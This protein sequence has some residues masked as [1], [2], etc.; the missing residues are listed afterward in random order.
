MFTVPPTQNSTSTYDPLAVQF[1]TQGQ[2]GYM[3]QAQYL[4]P[5]QYGA[6]RSMPGMQNSMSMTQQAPSLWQTYLQANRGNIMG[7]TGNYWV[8][9]YNPMQSQVDMQVMAQRRLSDAQHS[10]AAGFGGVV[11]QSALP[12]IG[13]ALGGPIGFMAGAGLSMVMPNMGDMMASRRRNARM[14]QNISV[15]SV[16]SGPDMATTTGRGFTL[17]ASGRLE[18]DIRSA[19]VDDMVFNQ[20]DYTSFL[21]KGVSSG[22]MD[23]SQTAKQYGDVVKKLRSNVKLLAEVLD[24]KDVSAIFKDMQRMQTMGA[25]IT[26]MQSIGLKEST[27]ARIAGL[28]H[29]EMVNTYGQQGAMQAMQ[30]GLTPYQGALSSMGNAALI[31]MAQRSGL[32]NP[33]ELARL[34]GVQGLTQNFNDGAGKS[35]TWVQE[36]ILPGLT[37]DGKFDPDKADAFMK[38]GVSLNQAMQNSAEQRRDLDR[39]RRIRINRGD[40][41]DAL[42]EHL[43]GNL[44]ALTTKVAKLFGEEITRGVGTPETKLIQGLTAMGFDPDAARAKAK[45]EFNED[46]KAK[47]AEQEAIEKNRQNEAALRQQESTSS[48]FKTNQ[49]KLNRFLHGLRDDIFGDWAADAER[50]ADREEAR[51]AGIYRTDDRGLGDTRLLTGDRRP[52]VT[53][54]DIGELLWYPEDNKYNVKQRAAFAR[55]GADVELA[56]TILSGLNQTGDAYTDTANIAKLETLWK[57]DTQK[58]WEDV[59]ALDKKQLTPENMNKLLAEV[60]GLSESKAAELY[61]TPGIYQS[62]AHIASV[63]MSEPELAEARKEA[64]KRVTKAKAEERRGLNSNI[65][66]DLAI[67]RRNDLRIKKRF[68][69]S[70]DMSKER[71]EA[72]HALLKE[73]G[74][75][76]RELREFTNDVDYT[77]VTQKD[78]IGALASMSDKDVDELQKQNTEADNLLTDYMSFKIHDGRSEEASKDFRLGVSSDL[79]KLSRERVGAVVSATNRRYDQVFKMLQEFTGDRAGAE[80]LVGL[81]GKSE[82]FRPTKGGE[83]KEGAMGLYGAFAMLGQKYDEKDLKKNED[84]F[85]KY[86]YN[87]GFLTRD[88][89]VSAEDKKKALQEAK[90]AFKQG[91]AAFLRKIA[92]GAGFKYSEEDIRKMEYSADG[93]DVKPSTKDGTKVGAIVGK[94]AAFNAARQRAARF[95]A[96]GAM[97][98]QLEE[99]MSSVA[100]GDVSLLDFI[101]SPELI[102]K[103]KKQYKAGSASAKSLGIVE[104][105]QKLQGGTLPETEIFKSILQLAPGAAG[106]DARSSYEYDPEVVKASRENVKQITEKTGTIS[107]T[108]NDLLEETKKV[109]QNSKEE[110]DAKKTQADATKTQAA[111]T[112]ALIELITNPNKKFR[113]H[114]RGDI[115]RD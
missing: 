74:I 105:I 38:G 45:L 19:A 95:G 88:P 4:T 107:T 51:K 10:M 40:N 34:G 42:T 68:L 57:G 97:T 21:Q 3:P 13:G 17:A 26:D 79:N 18:R 63:N 8:N 32:F 78:F 94:V 71:K 66:R 56:K 50:E 108:L 30:Y 58:L 90:D 91:D 61:G 76:E 101:A 77:E 114:K 80:H 100:I 83:L 113:A 72:A 41:T 37:T 6:F 15:P 93:L 5:S 24:N 9:T 11:A 110:A 20:E 84:Q 2:M 99:I 106:V 75:T 96:A 64:Q 62:I 103:A 60:S 35:A 115:L 27:F 14:L 49:R 54:E 102:A 87:Q 104:E 53:K 22:L 98:L 44:D 67:N 52:R 92:A 16:V 82:D 70:G 31:T 1:M 86:L 46:L 25:S 109:T 59:S 48:F 28:S 81:F 55:K 33:G 43:D 65:M 73:L 23:Y 36:N 7:M 29:Q 85:V 69:R 111:M 47:K 39:G 89:N 112:E 12:M